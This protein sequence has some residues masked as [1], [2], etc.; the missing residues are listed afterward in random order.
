[1]CIEREGEIYIYIYTYIYICIVQYIYT[2]RPRFPRQR[3]PP[4]CAFHRED[5]AASD[6][7]AFSEHEHELAEPLN[8]QQSAQNASNALTTTAKHLFFFVTKRNIPIEAIELMLSMSPQGYIQQN[9]T[10]AM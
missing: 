3:R 5:A 7:A 2:N 1:M 9:N 10:N 6:F 4:F 8:H